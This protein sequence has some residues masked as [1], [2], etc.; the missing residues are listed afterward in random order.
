LNKRLIV[1]Q[2]RPL[3]PKHVW[4]IRMRPD[5]ALVIAEVIEI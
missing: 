3:E 4:A 1:D 5:D 2:K